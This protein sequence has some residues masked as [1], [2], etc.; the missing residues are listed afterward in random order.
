MVGERREAQIL[1]GLG[2]QGTA[3]LIEA[4]AGREQIQFNCEACGVNETQ[5]SKLLE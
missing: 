3:A 2:S 4:K 1:I 5:E